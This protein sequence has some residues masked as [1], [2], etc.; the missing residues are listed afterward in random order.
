MQQRHRSTLSAILVAGAVAC[1]SGGG[2]TDGTVGGS[3]GAGG[4]AG[5]GGAVADAGGS[6]RRDGN[7]GDGGNDGGSDGSAALPSGWRNVKI[8]GGG[9][10]P[11][12]IYHPTA[13][14]LRYARTDIGGVYRWD[15]ASSSWVALTDGFSRAEGGN[16]GAES[17]ALDPT[18]PNRVYITTSQ[19]ITYGSE[20]TLYS[21]TDQGASWTATELPFPVRSNDPGRAIGER[22]MVDPN[23]PSTLFY[24]SRAAGLWKS[25]DSGATWAQVTSFSSTTLSPSDISAAGGNVVGAELVLFDTS[26]TNTKTP[27]QNIY[28][29][30][31]PDAYG[32]TAGLTGSL[33]KST[34][35][36]STWAAVSTPMS[37]YIPHMVRAADGLFY[38]VIT[39]TSGPGSR[40]PASLYK[41]DGTNWTK[42][43]DSPSAQAGL[44]GLSVVG[45]GP[46]TKV[47]LG[48]TNTWGA[49]SGQAI[50][51]RSADDGSTWTEIGYSG[52]ASYHTPT[53][54]DYWGWIDDAEIDP[55]NPDHVSF[56]FGGGIWSSNDAF[57]S[58]KPAWRFDV[59]GLEETCNLIL[60][61]PP[62]GASYLLASGQG[63][64]GSFVHTSLTSA[65]TRKPATSAAVGGWSNGSGIDMAWNNPAF[66][67]TVG[68]Q[69]SDN[70]SKGS[71]SSDSGQTW[72]AFPSL[73]SVATNAGDESN[74]AVTADGANIIWAISGQ[75]PYYTTDQGV[76]WKATDLPALSS[77]G[78]GSAYHM[79]ADRKNANK[80]YAFDHGGAWW[81]SGSA[82]VYYSTDG[83]HTFTASSVAP[84]VHMYGSSWLAVNPFVE[85]DVWLADGNNLYHSTDS[86]VGW[87]KLTTMATVGS[88]WTTQHGATLVG[89]GKPA[90]GA[91]Y[92]AA[93]YLDGTVGG[94]EGLF[95]SDDA[96]ATWTRV[97]DD[98]HQW[99]GIGRIA[100]DTSIYGRV[101]VSGGGRGIL[102]NP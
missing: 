53:G 89:L 38:V 68:R 85:G 51:Y 29:S 12:I 5:N 39:S 44:G 49:F 11:G 96:G 95:R 92:S 50:L 3:Q 62:P 20:G 45:S 15:A 54:V 86:G 70:T 48:V 37:G 69:N 43:K 40:G 64:V 28:V 2:T 35:G 19:S 42:L 21:S 33:C 10:V 101:Y 17:V 26:T 32:Q 82:K 6:A 25:T 94:V 84:T 63:D 79:A 97:N 4:N 73:P 100:P 93:V 47:V 98:A 75:I 41:F 99:G 46:S 13:P 9:Y 27:T 16:E 91:S 87:T 23:V 77:V 18:D 78:V 74:V 30:V 90:P 58:A 72:T 102:Y 67:V 34:D 7:A 1:G 59:D 61:A 14:N 71:Y 80:V 31:A 60:T 65:P 8:G 36:G 24:A 52:G 55:A 88:E 57:S 66:I 56:V 81:V 83:G 76:S 22:L